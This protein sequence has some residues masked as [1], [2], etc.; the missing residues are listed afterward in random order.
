MGTRDSTITRQ[1]CCDLLFLLLFP[2]RE[3][4]QY[5]NGFEILFK[6]FYN[7]MQATNILHASVAS[8]RVYWSNDTSVQARRSSI[9]LQFCWLGPLQLSKRNMTGFRFICYLSEK[10]ILAN[11]VK[12]VR[13]SN[14]NPG[15][16]R[17]SR[18]H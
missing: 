14:T 4:D 18:E 7:M 15:T 10:A 3:H 9:T 8:A 13:N 11:S 2:E 16:I 6:C 12:G 17:W 1:S 5:L